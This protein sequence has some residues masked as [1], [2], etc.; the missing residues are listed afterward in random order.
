MR[1]KCCVGCVAPKRHVGCHSK[2]EEYLKERAELTK[3]NEALRLTR[4]KD[5][6]TYD[7]NKIGYANA[8]KYR[9]EKKR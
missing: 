9:G 8:K 7:F 4:S 6:L 3:E 5:S 1:I 2:C